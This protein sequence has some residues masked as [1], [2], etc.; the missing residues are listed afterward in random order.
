M[1][2]YFVSYVVVIKE[3]DLKI[4]FGNMFFRSENTA[5]NKSSVLMLINEIV[6]SV[7]KEFDT[8]NDSDEVIVLSF[9][10]I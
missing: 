8:L 3:P 2:E 5:E 10:K 9:Q 4:T 1:K 6:I 7:K